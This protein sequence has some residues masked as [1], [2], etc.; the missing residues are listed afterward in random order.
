MGMDLSADSVSTHFLVGGNEKSI[1]RFAKCRGY[2][3]W[4]LIAVVTILGMGI[5]MVPTMVRRMSPHASMQSKGR[6]LEFDNWQ[7]VTEMANSAK[8][9]RFTNSEFVLAWH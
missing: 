3:T 9:R 7:N 1:G 5:L 8:E 2:H 4:Y 6:Q